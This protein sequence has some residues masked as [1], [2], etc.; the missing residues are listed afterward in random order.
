M[1]TLIKHNLHSFGIKA[2]SFSTLNTK[3][4][5][6]TPFSIY[7]HW[8]YCE[9][10]CTYCNFNKYINPRDPPHERLV[11]AMT[12]ELDFYLTDPRFGLKNKRLNSVY[13]GGGTPSLALSIESAKLQDFAKAGVNRLSLGIQ[14]FND[15]DLKVMGRDHSGTDAIRAITKAKQVF[16]KERLTFDL[17]FAR[18]GQTLEAWDDELKQGLELAGDHMSIYQLTMERSTPLHK[19]SVRGELPPLPSPDE[20]A[21]MYEQTLK[22]TSEYGFSHYEVSNYCQ[23]ESA[24]SRHNFSYW[25]GMDYLGVGP[26]AHGRLTRTEDGVRV[27]TFGEFHPNKYMALCESEG[28]GIRKMVPISARETIEELIVFGM[29]T[30]MGV[31]RARFQAMTGLYLDNVLDK[32]MLQTYIEAGFLIDEAGVMDQAMNKYVPNELLSEWDLHGGIRP[33][34]SGLERMDSIVPHIM[35]IQDL[36]VE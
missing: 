9:S 6:K 35:K 19:A 4:P 20:A 18:P 25:Q 11:K 34:E 21:D 33:T 7:I 5:A 16:H 15:K 2:Q 36:P 17:I 30:R 3:L 24:I 12:R 1:R 13:F 27:R 22:R 29:R 31:P 8:P 32:E 10:K 23:N 26:G 28:E 14:S